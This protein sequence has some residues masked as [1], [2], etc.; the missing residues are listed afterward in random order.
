[1]AEYERIHSSGVRFTIAIG[2][3]F[4]EVENVVEENDGYVVVQKI[5]VAAEEAERLDPAHRPRRAWRNAAGLAPPAAVSYPASSGSSTFPTS[6][7]RSLLTATPERHS[8]H[9]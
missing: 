5:G 9:S 1:V 4:P 6:P 7:I 8:R 3:D 2:H